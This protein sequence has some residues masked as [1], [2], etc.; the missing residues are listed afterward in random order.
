MVLE[1]QGRMTKTIF[2]T[3]SKGVDISGI[4]QFWTAQITQSHRSDSFLSLH[5]LPSLYS[6]SFFFSPLPGDAAP[7]RGRPGP[8][9]LQQPERHA[10]Q[11]GR[12]LDLFPVQSA[13]RP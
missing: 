9:S 8:P 13:D 4:G 12:D 7:D 10:G 5:F 2:L 3:V 1:M 6:L 11:G